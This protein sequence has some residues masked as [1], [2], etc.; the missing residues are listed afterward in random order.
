MHSTRV[1]DWELAVTCKSSSPRLACPTL[2]IGHHSQL[3]VRMYLNPWSGSTADPSIRPVDG[4]LFLEFIPFASGNLLT[5]LSVCTYISE[6][7]PPLKRDCVKPR[8]TFHQG[9]PNPVNEPYAARRED[10]FNEEKLTSDFHT[11]WPVGQLIASLIAWG[12]IP[13]YSCATDLVSW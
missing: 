6:F 13:N 10:L 3:H 1:W 11:G 2:D 7:F 8:S 9:R 12:F 4:A 5:L